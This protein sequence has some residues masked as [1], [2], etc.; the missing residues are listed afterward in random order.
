[1]E[2]FSVDVEDDTLQMGNGDG[3]V[4]EGVDHRLLQANFTETAGLTDTEILRTTCKLYGSI[5]AVLFVLFLLVRN[6][7]PEIFNLKKTFRE[8]STPVAEVRFPVFFLSP[9]ISVLPSFSFFS[10]THHSYHIHTHKTGVPRPHQLDLE[11]LWGLLQ[12]DCGRMRHGR[13]DNYSSIRVGRQAFAGWCLQF[14][15][16][17]PSL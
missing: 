13:G 17:L 8:L 10:F 2:S 7:K 1:M 15:L 6:M 4:L 14:H 9:T 3:S 12:H 5:F 11:G 16:S